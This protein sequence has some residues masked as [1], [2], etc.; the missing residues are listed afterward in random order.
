MRIDLSESKLSGIEYSGADEK[1]GI[2]FRGERYLVKFQRKNLWGQEYNDVS[3]YI[4]S[5]IFNML[6]IKTQ[7]TF[8]VVLN[9]RKAVACKDFCYPNIIFLDSN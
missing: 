8:L 3:E 7:D 2:V 4:C 5:K 6:G 1:L 9:G